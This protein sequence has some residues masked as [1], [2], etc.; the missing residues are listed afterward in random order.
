[1]ALGSAAMRE[2][3]VEVDIMVG[4]LRTTIGMAGCHVLDPQK[5]AVAVGKLSDMRLDRRD[6]GPFDGARS[7]VRKLSN[8]TFVYLDPR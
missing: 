5:V 1:M 6:L 7:E 4:R 3:A 8:P 2:E